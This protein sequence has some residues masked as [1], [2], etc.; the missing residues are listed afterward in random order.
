MLFAPELQ[1]ERLDARLLE[2]G[3]DEREHLRFEVCVFLRHGALTRAGLAVQ[4]QGRGN[5]VGSGV[6][7]RLCWEQAGARKRGWSA[8]RSAVQ[9][10]AQS[11]TPVDGGDQYGGG[12]SASG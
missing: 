8:V 9:G 12:C 7:W 6:L 3:L 5:G 2:G 11:G 10:G 1:G 4:R